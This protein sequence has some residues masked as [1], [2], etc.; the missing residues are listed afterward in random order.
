ML[1][2]LLF[3]KGQIHRYAAEDVLCFPAR[4]VGDAASVEALSSKR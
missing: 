1:M 2:L 3:V 4:V